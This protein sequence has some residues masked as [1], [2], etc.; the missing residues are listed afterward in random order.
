VIKLSGQS[1]LYW[2][3]GSNLKFRI[4]T[5]LDYNELRWLVSS[6]YSVYFQYKQI[7][8]IAYTS[9]VY[10]AKISYQSKK[11]WVNEKHFS[12][13]FSRRCVFCNFSCYFFDI[14]NPFC[15]HNES[16]QWYFF[17]NVFVFSVFFSFLFFSFES[18]YSLKF[19]HLSRFKN[20]ISP[21]NVLLGKFQHLLSTLKHYNLAIYTVKWLQIWLTSS[22]TCTLQDCLVEISITQWHLDP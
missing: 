15:R 14:W 12:R 8:K 18:L 19:F 21:P 11:W 10:V 5:F 22:T 1:N 16:I 20:R 17:T 4:S 9:L 7:G 13:R 6:S 3:F 2:M